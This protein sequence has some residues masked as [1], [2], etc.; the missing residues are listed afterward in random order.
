MSY[1][2]NEKE[3]PNKSHS[4]IHD[5]LKE[6]G[7]TIK[8]KRKLRLSKAIKAKIYCSC[9]I[10]AMSTALL[11]NYIVDRVHDTN[12]A[13]ATSLKNE[14]FNHIVDYI[15]IL[16]HA[17]YEDAEEVSK[18]IESDIKE[19]DMDELKA[20]LDNGIF[21][22]DLYNIIRKNIE[23]KSFNSIDNF[24]NDII[25]MTTKGV[26]EDL[27][28]KRASEST[29]RDWDYEVDN[30][31]NKSLER[32]AI[33]KLLSHSNDIIVTEP[34]NIIKSNTEHKMLDEFSFENL[35]DV[36]MKEGIEGLKNYQILVPVYITD[37]GDIFGQNDVVKGVKQNTHKMIV[38]QEFN[39]YDQLEL[40]SPNLFD[41]LADE[42]E[43]ENIELHFKYI[44]A[45]LYILGIIYV[46]ELVFIFFY[47]TTKYNSFIERPEPDKEIE[48]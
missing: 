12:V 17:A 20:D 48:R 41:V 44:I 45:L 23:G 22:E 2:N 46:I 13:M 28:I 5:N 14:S 15:N 1:V 36:Y 43:V 29:I 9:M 39:I 4:K 26:Y 30:A 21:N 24:R 6:N 35:E 34:V 33:D 19:C 31:Y 25:I 37:T 3:Y 27:N 10:I 11:L 47:F 38:V 8:P 42:Q 40:A 18:N 32:D 16:K 7:N